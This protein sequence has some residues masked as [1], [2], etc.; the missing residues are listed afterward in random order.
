MTKENATEV[1]EKKTERLDIRVSHQKKQAFTQAFSSWKRGA[2]WAASLLIL[3]LM[4]TTIWGF[5][6]NQK[7]NALTAE[8][9]AVYDKDGN[10]LIEPGEISPDDFHLH[11]V[12]SIDGEDGISP[13]EFILRGTMVWEFVNP[14]NFQIIENKDGVFKHRVIKRSTVGSD[15]K[16]IDP[17][18]QRLVKIDGEFVELDLENED[19]YNK[20]LLSADA[21]KEDFRIQPEKSEAMKE[22]LKFYSKKVV[23]FDLRNPDK[24]EL[25]VLEQQSTHAPTQTIS[26]YQRSV[27]WVEGRKTPELVMGMGRELA[28]LTNQNAEAP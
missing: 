4:G 15:G 13:E 14:D 25:S 8:L 27:D 17:S 28:V 18:I 3:G 24:F 23:K 16:S 26:G 22:R 7:S 5:S 1:F 20:L 12:L 9:F 6:V 19:Q 21:T 2:G 10:G 11:R